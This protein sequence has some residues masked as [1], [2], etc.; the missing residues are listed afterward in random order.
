[1]NLAPHMTLCTSALTMRAGS[2]GD[3]S[4]TRAAPCPY[5]AWLPSQPMHY[6][7]P[8]R[9]LLALLSWWTYALDLRGSPSAGFNNR[10]YRN[11]A[12]IKIWNI[13]PDTSVRCRVRAPSS[14]TYA[15]LRYTLRRAISDFTAW[16]NI[17]PL[18]AVARA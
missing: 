15:G 16:R 13:K 10:A 17:C 11:A 12:S 2:A 18:S 9:L 5:L 6:N 3:F 1:M 4:G 7:T 8:A 14:A